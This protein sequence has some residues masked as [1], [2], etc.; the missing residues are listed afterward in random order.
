[1]SEY[2]KYVIETKRIIC[3]NKA[4]YF[5]AVKKGVIVHGVDSE[6]IK[7]PCDYFIEADRVA[8]LGPYDQIIK[9]GTIIMKLT[10]HTAHQFWQQH[11]N[12]YHVRFDDGSFETAVCGSTISLLTDQSPT[13]KDFEEFKL[14]PSTKVKRADDI[15]WFI[16]SQ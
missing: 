1:M 4:K 2:A 6:I 9:K 16:S 3:S 14:I 7:V 12:E 15:Y 8:L 13:E 5:E 11:E 10:D